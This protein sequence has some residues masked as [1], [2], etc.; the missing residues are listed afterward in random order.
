MF[1]TKGIRL[2]M[3]FK[4]SETHTPEGIWVY[5]IEYTSIIVYSD[6]SFD[7]LNFLIIR[8]WWARPIHFL[9]YW[10]IILLELEMKGWHFLTISW[11]INHLTTHKAGSKF[12]TELIPS[13]RWL[14]TTLGFVKF[15]ILKQL[16]VFVCILRAIAP[17][18]SCSQ[19]SV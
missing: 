13:C 1:E 16:K 17:N 5:S 18:T 12:S 4:T 15:F 7:E 6:N 11:A 10:V 19:N 2:P 8:R 3:S 9:V 14:W